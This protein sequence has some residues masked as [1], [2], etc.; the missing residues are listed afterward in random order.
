LSAQR[1]FN[2]SEKM[3]NMALAHGRVRAEY[4]ILESWPRVAG[5]PGRKVPSA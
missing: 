2:L 4:S 1:P 5:L 3:G